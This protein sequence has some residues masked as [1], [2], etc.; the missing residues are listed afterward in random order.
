MQEIRSHT[1]I[2]GIAASLVVLMHLAQYFVPETVTH[3]ALTFVNSADIMVDLFFVLSG[4]V[5]CHV[6]AERMEAMPSG[7]AMSEFF[8]ARLARIYPLHF[9]TTLVMVVLYLLQGKLSDP[10]LQVHAA[11]SFA[12]VHGWTPAYAHFEAFNFPSWSISG[13]WAAYLAFPTL[14]LLSARR[15][16]SWL[17]PALVVAGYAWLETAFSGL[18]LHKGAMLQRAIPGFALGMLLHR[19][20]GIY[21][22]M[23]PNTRRIVLASALAAVAVAMANAVFS[24]VLVLPLAAVVLLTSR[25]EGHVARVLS[26]PPLRWLGRISYSIYLLHVP[27]IYLAI[28]TIAQTT[29]LD[30]LTLPPGV[31]IGLI[32]GVTLVSGELSFRFF[33]TPLRRWIRRTFRP[34]RSRALKPS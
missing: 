28:P 24:V 1:S 34:A 27:V 29:G 17:L 31:L 32:L 5:L 33:E 10:G 30:P 14:L 16:A 11:K 9:A 4:F 15:G 2:R 8:V 19:H 13:E 12:L 25:D 20:R 6:Y 26:V 18:M 7:A 23:T 22:L 3:V 21:D